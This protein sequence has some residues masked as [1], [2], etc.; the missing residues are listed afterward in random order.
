MKLRYYLR[1]LGTGILVTILIMV[2]SGDKQ[3]KMS[4]AEIM[5]RAAKLG[6]IESTTLA[7]PTSTQK[8]EITQEPTE[9]P[10]SEVTEEPTEEPTPEVTEELTEEPTPEVTEE[11]TQEPTP[12][13]TEEPT[14]E[15]TPEVT[16]E[17]TQE[18]T[19][20]VTEEPMQE[21]TPEVTEEPMQE[22]TQDGGG[23]NVDVADAETVQVIVY[24]GDSSEKVSRAVAQAG[25][26][27]D[28]ED[29]N[30]YL[31]DYGFARKLAIGTHTIPVN[32]TYEEIAKE[33][34]SRG[35]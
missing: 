32:A 30:R 19:P 25:L 4:D 33:L 3:Q 10:T 29:F 15:P 8:N 20:E 9:E 31:C 12:E 28:A 17:P 22:T 27:E 1:G 5:A 23:V 7:E 26:V 35:K 21:T 2:A 34:V 14:Q 13:V 16:E 6:M 24:S 18:P 11:P